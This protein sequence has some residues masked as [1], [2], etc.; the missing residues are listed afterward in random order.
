[1]LSPHLPESHGGS[2]AQPTWTANFQ[3][4]HRREPTTHPRTK[5]ELDAPITALQPAAELVGQ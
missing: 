3:K 4:A 2:A 5:M 1:M